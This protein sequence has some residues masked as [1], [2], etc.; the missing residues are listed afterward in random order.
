MSAP[1]TMLFSRLSNNFWEDCVPPEDAMERIPRLRTR[2]YR[3]Y[4]NCDL[5]LAKTFWF[6]SGY[7]SIQSVS[8]LAVL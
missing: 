5:E 4:F 6:D 7:L 2:Y 3:P 1:V 8:S